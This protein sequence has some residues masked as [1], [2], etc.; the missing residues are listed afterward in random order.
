MKEG[1]TNVREL[2]AVVN[3]VIDMSC[4]VFAGWFQLKATYVRMF[5]LRV[6]Q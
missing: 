6:L 2:N 4:T 1:V 5:S 3:K